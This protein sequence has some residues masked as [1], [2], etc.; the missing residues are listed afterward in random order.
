MEDEK[1]AEEE[2]GAEDTTDAKAEESDGRDKL[3]KIG[4]PGK[5]ILVDYFQENRTFRRSFLLLRISFPGR[6]IFIQC[7]RT[8][9]EAEAIV[10]DGNDVT[11]EKEEESQLDKL[12][13]KDEDKA[14]VKIQSAYKG[15]RT[16]KK[17]AKLMAEEDRDG[18]GKKSEK[19][20][21]REKELKLRE[22][23]DERARKLQE[24]LEEIDDEELK[25]KQERR[26]KLKEE[27]SLS[28]F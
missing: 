26:Q 15:F 10:E 21:E 28:I 24:K 22:S 16:R 19:K 20:D 9:T 6:P 4:L 2:Q 18:R 11:K 27:K 17:V 25:F 13:T 3:Y 5:S 8:S 12:D 23:R 7:S 14:A 1:R